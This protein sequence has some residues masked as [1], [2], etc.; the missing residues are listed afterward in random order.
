MHEENRHGVFLWIQTWTFKCK[1]GM[2]FETDVSQDSLE[3]A[4][5]EDDTFEPADYTTW[6]KCRACELIDYFAKTIHKA[7]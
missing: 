4:C 2:K 5:R 1:D 7:L 3:V 6:P